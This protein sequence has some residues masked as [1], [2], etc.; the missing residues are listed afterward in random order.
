MPGKTCHKSL[1]SLLRV[2]C[3]SARNTLKQVN[4]VCPSLLRRF[5]DGGDPA[6]GPG[7]GGEDVAVAVGGHRVD[8]EVVPSLSALNGRPGIM[9]VPGPRMI[10]ILVNV[11]FNVIE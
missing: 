1:L 9:G 4:C 3:V 11:K 5:G 2:G 6:V 8:G 10:C 7:E